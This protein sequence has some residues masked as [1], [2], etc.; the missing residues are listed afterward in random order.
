M[1]WAFIAARRQRL[2]LLE[3][4][5]SGIC[6]LQPLQHVGSVVVAPGLQ[7]TQ[8]TVV[9]HRLCCSNACGV[10]LHQGSNECLLHWQVGSLPLSNLGSLLK[11]DIK[12]KKKRCKNSLVVGK[13]QIKA[14]IKCHFIDKIGKNLCFHFFVSLVFLKR[15]SIKYFLESKMR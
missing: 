1:C 4:M 8:S 9:G 15:Y 3:M 7:S 6:G 13:T 14:I 10:F 2:L 5:G 11:K 12:K